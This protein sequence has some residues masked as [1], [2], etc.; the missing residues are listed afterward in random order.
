VPESGKAAAP[1]LRHPVVVA[2][3]PLAH[4]AVRHLH[5]RVTCTKARYN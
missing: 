1:P 5:A 4:T 3:P 2:V